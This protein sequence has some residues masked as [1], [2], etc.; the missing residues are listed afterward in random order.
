MA[1]ALAAAL[2]AGNS[3]PAG[4]ADPPPGRQ[5]S[6]LPPAIASS[7]SGHALLTGI[8]QHVVTNSKSRVEARDESVPTSAN[9]VE[10]FATPASKTDSEDDDRTADLPTADLPTT[11]GEAAEFVTNDPEAV[12]ML[13]ADENWLNY[14]R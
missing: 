7:D 2:A 9:R 14:H 13:F 12:G 8:G 4:I 5:R 6:A 11:D 10:I 1:L 3:N